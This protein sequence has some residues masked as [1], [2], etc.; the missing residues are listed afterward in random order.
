MDPGRS[1]EGSREGGGRRTVDGVMAMDFVDCN[2][3][4]TDLGRC[5]GASDAEVSPTSGGP[6]SVVDVALCL[7]FLLLLRRKLPQSQ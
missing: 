2:N 7:L 5:L 4:A 6:F 3:M 1:R